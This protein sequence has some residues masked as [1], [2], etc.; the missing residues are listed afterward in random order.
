M[1]MNRLFSPGAALI[2]V[3]LTGGLAIAYPGQQQYAGQAKV[4][5]TKAQS[6]ALKTVPGGKITGEE[7]EQERGGSGLRYSF[8]VRIHGRTHEVGIDAR[9]GKVLE[10][11]VEGANSD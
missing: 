1:S 4:S 5:L 3:L 11:S 8:D 6:I 9:T 2:A 7:L 10:N